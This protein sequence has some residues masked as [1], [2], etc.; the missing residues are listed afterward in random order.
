MHRAADRD[1]QMLRDLKKGSLCI[2]N[3]L[4]RRTDEATHQ[5]NID[6]WPNACLEKW[7]A[8]VQVGF[9]VV[10]MLPT[11]LQ[12]SETPWYGWNRREDL[13]R[14]CALVLSS[15]KL[16]S[17]TISFFKKKTTGSRDA[18]ETVSSKPRAPCSS[19][20]T[21]VYTDRLPTR[22]KYENNN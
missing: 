22:Q 16:Y 1:L 14:S 5:T 11:S 10:V 12:I 17:S 7:N 18:E 4:A 20:T 19:C 9:D 6:Q 2:N 15:P 8:L 3:R 21:Y 13:R